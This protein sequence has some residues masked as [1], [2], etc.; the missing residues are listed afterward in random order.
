MKTI[1]ARAITIMTVVAMLAF[2]TTFI[3]NLKREGDE[4]NAEMELIPND[5][6]K[7]GK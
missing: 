5:L 6:N 4:V 7:D 1:V 3:S 2:S